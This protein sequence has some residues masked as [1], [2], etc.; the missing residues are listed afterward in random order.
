MKARAEAAENERSEL[1]R[2]FANVMEDAKNLK[3][4]VI[5]LLEREMLLECLVFLSTVEIV[6]H[7]WKRRNSTLS[8][9]YCSAT[10]VKTKTCP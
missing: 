1:A 3:V 2:H 9:S 4:S 10:V 8:T 5:S 6:S 7:K